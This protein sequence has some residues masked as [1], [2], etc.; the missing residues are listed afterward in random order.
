M[1]SVC[2]IIKDISR[3]TA[4]PVLGRSDR[5]SIS[6][7]DHHD[8]NLHG[9]TTDGRRLGASVADARFFPFVQGYEDA[10]ATIAKL[11]KG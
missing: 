8:W 5:H 4:I 10:A 3:L 7:K 2:S 9:S 11:S 6:L 1:F